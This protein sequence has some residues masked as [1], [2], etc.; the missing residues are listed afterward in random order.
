MVKLMRCPFCGCLAGYSRVPQQGFSLLCRCCGAIAMH[1]EARERD[2]LGLAWNRRA[3]PAVG[4]GPLAP[5]PFCGGQVPPSAAGA[6]G[7]IRCPSCGMMIAFA[8]SAS[9]AE[10]RVLWN[11]RSG[12]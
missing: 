10:S 6:G 4:A 11:R 2:A 3:H 1:E 12:V 7:I 9:A 5:C 8:G